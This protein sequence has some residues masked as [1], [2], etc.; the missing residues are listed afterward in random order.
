MATAADE[1]YSPESVVEAQEPRD[2][3]RQALEVLPLRCRTLL[4]ALAY[5]A[6]NSYADISVALEMPVGSI[7]PTR[8]RCLDRL[9]RG[10]RADAPHLLGE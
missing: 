3:A 10:L 4:R 8:G 1:A 6:G 9:R 5:S 7:G 2:L